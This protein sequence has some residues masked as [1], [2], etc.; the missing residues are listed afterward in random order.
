MTEMADKDGTRHRQRT[1][2]QTDGQTGRQRQLDE[3]MNREINGQTY[4]KRD[5]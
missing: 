1:D 5:G 2:I 4:E 3:W